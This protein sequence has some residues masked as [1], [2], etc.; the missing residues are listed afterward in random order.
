VQARRDADRQRTEAESLVEF[1]Q[2]DLRD[3]LRSVGRLDVMSAVNQR[4]LLYYDRQL[5]RNDRPLD[6]AMRART[7]HA[8]GETALDQGN[9]PAAQ[10]A[11][12]EAY[13]ATAA[14]VARW[15]NDAQVIFAHAQSEYWMGYFDYLRGNVTSARAAW[16]RYKAL[17]DRLLGLDGGNP[18]WLTEASYAEGNLCA[19]AMRPPI[20]A[21]TALATCAAALDR[22]RRVYRLRGAD[23]DVIKDLANR[24]GWMTNVLNANGNWPRALANRRAHE[25]LIEALIR[26]EPGNLDYRDI[27]ARSQLGFGELLARRGEH[28]EARRRF[29]RSAEEIAMLRTHDPSNASWRALEQRIAQDMQQERGHGSH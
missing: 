15:P 13:R 2:T 5:A 14:L 19:I 28:Q 25:A 17:T 1:M 29:R 22:M 16:Q 21:A 3:R 26:H 18:R 11:F 7:G 6:S 8:I 9:Q 20:E 27:R 23:P 4:T 10:A 12:R 24:Y